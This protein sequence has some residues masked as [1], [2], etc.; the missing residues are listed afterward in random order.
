[1]TGLPRGNFA[2]SDRFQVVN[3]VT[4]V[5]EG[6][7]RKLQEALQCLDHACEILT[8]EFNLENPR[9]PRKESIDLQVACFRLKDAMG[10]VPPVIRGPDDHPE[11]P[12]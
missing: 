5:V 9:L 3:Y 6:L 11:G 2:G 4:S 7:P 12:G 10:V 8:E 1:M